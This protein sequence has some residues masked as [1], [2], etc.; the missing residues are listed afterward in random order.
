[1]IDVD[2][3]GKKYKL[4]ENWDEITMREYC[5]LFYNLPKGASDASG[6]T[7]TTETLKTEAVI[8]S[9]LLGE[10]DD[11][12]QGLPIPVFVFLQH[13]IKFIYD[14][15]NFLSGGGVFYLKID[16]KK[17]WMPSPNEM[18]LRQY[19]DADMIMKEEGKNQF[20]ELLACLLLPYGKDGKVEYNGD[21]KSLIPKIEQMRASEGLPFIY[22]F[23]KKK[24]ISKSLSS[25]SSKALEEA[26]RLR[27]H[28]QSS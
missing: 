9:R 20:I 1:M 12:V 19:I 2:I 4:P 23:F 27:Q 5:D 16:G 26:D 15:G 10:K 11:F 14:I 13:H 22:T 6:A 18:S 7:E 28:I 25:R 24:E 3:E 17:Y 21:Y 8:I